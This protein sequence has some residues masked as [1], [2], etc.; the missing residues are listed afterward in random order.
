MKLRLQSFR[1]AVIG[2]ILMLRTQVH[3][4][5]HV[6]ATVMV[7][8]L[9]FVLKVGRNDWLALII[10]MAMVWTAE[11]INTAI[12][13]TCD[14]ITKD[15]MPLIGHAKDVAAGA[16]LIASIFAAIIG[17]VVLVPKFFT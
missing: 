2:I 5:W 12:E 3:A 6:L 9:G 15:R 1:C 13:I 8:I 17:A 11:A 7:I 16:V 4:R 10:A 14:A